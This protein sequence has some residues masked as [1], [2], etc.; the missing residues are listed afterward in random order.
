[1]GHIVRT[2][3]LQK[4]SFLCGESF[5]LILLDMESAF[6]KAVRQLVVKNDD[7]EPTDEYV[8]HISKTLG[9]DLNQHAMFCEHL[10]ATLMLERGQANRAVQQ[11]IL[12]SMEGSWCKL[13]DSN[14]CLATSLGTKP[15]DPTAD[16]LYSLVMTKYLRTVQSKLA[17]R[18]SLQGCIHAMTWVDDVILPFQAKADC[19]YDKASVILE[20]MHNTA[21]EMGMTPNLKRGKTEVMLGFAGKGSQGSKREFES[22]EP[23]VHFETTSGPRTVEVV[24]DAVYLGAILD[25]KGRLMQEITACTGSSV[26]S[27]KK[28][29]LTNEKVPVAQRRAVLQSLALSKSNY[30]SGAWL[31][32]KKS[33]ERAWRTKVMKILGLLIPIKYGDEKHLTDDEVMVMVGMVSPR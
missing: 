18:P 15:G 33:E 6:Y 13:S 28:N 32:L 20:V 31:P 22:K 23:L 1:M 4:R 17:K 21:T 2:K 19:V 9:M 27:L 3:M 30:T 24:P 26:R 12:S 29:V 5:G 7:F 8:A 16:V 25:A 10:N 14:K 11:W